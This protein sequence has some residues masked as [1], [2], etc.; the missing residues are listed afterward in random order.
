MVTPRNLLVKFRGQDT[1]PGAN[2]H[3]AWCS[4]K[5]TKNMN[6]IKKN[7]IMHHLRSYFTSPEI[8]HIL[9]RQLYFVHYHDSTQPDPTKALHLQIKE[10]EKETK[11][12]KPFKCLQDKRYVSS[13]VYNLDQSKRP[14]TNKPTEYGNAAM[15]EASASPNHLLCMMH[16]ALLEGNTPSNLPVGERHRTRYQ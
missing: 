10:K 5:G 16:A 11:N 13:M 14:E 3:P 12:E 4:G 2:L 6:K 9:H 7:Q 15:C 8:A 1:N